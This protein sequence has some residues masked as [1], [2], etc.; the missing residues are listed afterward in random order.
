LTAQSRNRYFRTNIPG[1]KIPEDKGV[2][3]SEVLEKEVDEKYFIDWQNITHKQI[4]LT[5]E[6]Q[7]PSALIES[8]TEIGKL[9]RKKNAER[10]GIK[11]CYRGK[12]DKVFISKNTNKANCLS[13]A[14]HII[15]YIIVYKEG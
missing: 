8:R 13:K 1:L 5:G 12:E 3:L 6:E 2:L 15:N 4:S 7:L 14:H 10:Y 9:K 11:K